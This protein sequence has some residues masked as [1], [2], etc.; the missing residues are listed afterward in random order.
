MAGPRV[1]HILRKYDPEEWGGTET[2]VAAVTRL[3]PEHGW[4]VEVHAPAGPTAPDCAL[5]PEVALRRYRAFCPFLGSRE[6]RRGLWANAGNIASFD[7][8]IRLFRDRRLSLAHAH[9]LGRIGAG[10][11]AAMRLT[12]RPYVVSLHGPVL[13]ERE[14]V[15]AQTARRLEGVLDLGRPIG[16]LLG[17]HRVLDDAARVI[18]FNDAERVALA[19]RVGDRAV[20]MD[21]GVDIERLRSGDADRARRRWPELGAAPVVALVGRI[22]A[23]KNQIL[24]VRAFARGAPPDHRLALPGAETDPGYRAAVEREARALGVLG[25]V[26]FLGNLDPSAEIPDLFARATLIIVPSTH[27]SFGLAVLEGWAAGRPVLFARRTGLEDLARALLDDSVSLPTLDERAWAEAMRQLL[28]SADAQRAAAEAGGRLLRARFRW[29]VVVE[30]LAALYEEVL[31]EL[32]L[33]GVG[34]SRSASP[35]SPL[36]G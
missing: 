24:A 23:Q 1:A 26:H 15:A 21:H 9:T 12:G 18:T 35:I 14:L 19:S 30:R 6:R 28:M 8:P 34:G 2:H 7:E 10:V 4:T 5:A 25:R 27:E 3:L 20:R 29:S 13:A 32:P 36:I 16:L 33:R 11:R 17:A 31:G 22:A